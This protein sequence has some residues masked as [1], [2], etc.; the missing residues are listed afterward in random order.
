MNTG[1]VRMVASDAIGLAAERNLNLNSDGRCK[2]SCGS[3][4]DG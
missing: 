4:K 3:F 2:V 1:E